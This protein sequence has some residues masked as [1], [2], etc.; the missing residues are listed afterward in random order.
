M[1]NSIKRFPELQGDLQPFLHTLGRLPGHKR[2]F[3]SLGLDI[4]H[5]PAALLWAKIADPVTDMWWRNNFI[6][7]V[8]QVT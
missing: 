3:R 7:V 5:P 4:K 2:D 6:L 8:L 1:G